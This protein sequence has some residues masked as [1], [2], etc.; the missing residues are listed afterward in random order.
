MLVFTEA[1]SGLSNMTFSFIFNRDPNIELLVDLLRIDM[2]DK[3]AIES[4]VRKCDD[5]YYD[6]IFLDLFPAE[7]LR[8]CLNFFTRCSEEV[9]QRCVFNFV[10]LNIHLAHLAGK[11]SIGEFTLLTLKPNFMSITTKEE[12][13]QMILAAADHPKA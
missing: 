6:V 8:F 5:Y 3:E 7:A 12:M 10:P 13:R 1:G 11:I 4:A 9:Q 2:L